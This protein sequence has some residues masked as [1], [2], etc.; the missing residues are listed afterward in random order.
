M[1]PC[2]PTAGSWQDEGSAK[3]YGPRFCQEI[4]SSEFT[5]P[6]KDLRPP[7]RLLTKK[8]FKMEGI[9]MLRDLMKKGDWLTSVD[10]KDA[11]LSI[12]T[13]TPHRKFL[14]FL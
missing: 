6:K 5:V 11:Y 10:L 7:N 1:N 3:R 9:F 4:L 14:R 8:R 2:F 13:V 12:P